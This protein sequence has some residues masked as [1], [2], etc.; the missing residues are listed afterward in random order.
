MDRQLPLNLPVRAA[1]GRGDFFVASPN[2]LALAMIDAPE[3]WPQGK[4]LLVGPEGAG[5]SHLAAVWAAATGAVIIEAQTLLQ[6]PAAPP[7]PGSAIVIEDAD[8][9]GG[10]ALAETA[11]F[12][13]HNLVL[14]SGG[15]ILMT[16]RKPA[17]DW[18][19]ALPDLASRVAATAM[20]RIDPPDDNLLSAMILKQFADRQLQISPTLLPYLITRIDRSFAAALQLVAALDARALALGRPVTRALAAELLDSRDQ[21]AP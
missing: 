2:A 9:I 4:L 14:A 13:L 18:G 8:Q 5:K 15:Q 12:H 16:A 21:Q 7:T 6:G 1:L 20:A 11:L 17:R 19:I 3:T 10:N